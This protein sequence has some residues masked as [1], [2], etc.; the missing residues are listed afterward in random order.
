M[1]Y[2]T[3]MIPTLGRV[4][5]QTTLMNLPEE[6]REAAVLVVKGHE[7]DEYEFEYSDICDIHILPDDVVGISATRQHC[8]ETC[9]TEFL[10]MLDDDLAFFKRDEITNKL[11]KSTDDE[12]ECMFEELIDALGFEEFTLVGVSSRSG[13]NHVQ[14]DYKDVTRQGGFHGVNIAKFNEEGLRFDTSEVMEDFN[15]LLDMFTQGIPNR[16]FYKYCW[17]QKGGSG[18]QGGCSTFRTPEV[19]HACALALKERYPDFV[20]V[21]Q[22]Q[23]KTAWKGNGMETRTDVRMQWKKAYEFG[24]GL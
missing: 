3:L 7:A 21:V 23:S 22:K 17:D 8:I 18:M 5:M 1:D 10:F 16:V 11:G 20:T 13:N 4:N 12:I 6:I 15:L 19:Q 24:R 14:D 9:K 2:A